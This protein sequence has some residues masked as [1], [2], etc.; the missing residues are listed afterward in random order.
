[1]TISKGHPA[2]TT[3]LRPD[4]LPHQLYSKSLVES[5]SSPTD[6]GTYTT[7]G[8]SLFT[9]ASSTTSTTSSPSPHPRTR[10]RTWTSGQSD[11]FFEAMLRSLD[12]AAAETH[13]AHN[14][15]ERVRGMPTKLHDKIEGNPVRLSAVTGSSF[16]VHGFSPSRLVGVA[17]D[18]APGP[19]H[20]KSGQEPAQG[21]QQGATSSQGPHDRTRPHENLMPDQSQD[22]PAFRTTEVPSQALPPNLKIWQPSAAHKS[23]SELESEPSEVVREALEH[24]GSPAQD[25]TILCSH[26]TSR[27]SLLREQTS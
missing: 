4:V 8:E 15:R 16:D 11:Q 2:S 13:Q 3:E 19:K 1:M 12:K 17:Y 18:L 25:L 9:P 7:S 5:G 23:G 10:S 21:S 26:C 24:Y 27:S 6:S 20:L 22:H 14:R